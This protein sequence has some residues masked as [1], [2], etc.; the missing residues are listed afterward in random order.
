MFRFFHSKATATVE[1]S[2]FDQTRGGFQGREERGGSV[3]FV[4]VIISGQ[5]LSVG[6]AKLTSPSRLATS[7]PVHVA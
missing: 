2:R 6:E 1:V 4:A 3:P 7:F 5:G